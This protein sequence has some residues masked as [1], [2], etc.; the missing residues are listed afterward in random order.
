MTT[1]LNEQS[2]FEVEATAKATSATDGLWLKPV[3]LTRVTGFTL[4]PEG[5]C[6]DAI[7]VP[8]PRGDK[9][10]VDAN[11]AIDAA[12]FWRHMGHPV[13]H[14]EA[15][16]TWALGLGAAERTRT[17]ETFEAPDFQLPDLAGR[18]HTLTEHRGKKVFLATWASW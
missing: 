4:K 12:A 11:G 16:Q 17:L 3:D 10:F 13:V 7:C 15:R 8:V 2:S 18:M 1:I 5:L 14:D 9:S 6:R